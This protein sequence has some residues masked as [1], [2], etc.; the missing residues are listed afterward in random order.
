LAIHGGNDY[1]VPVLTEL[2]MRWTITDPAGLY[3][4]GTAGGGGHSGAILEK[5]QS[6][7]SMILIDRDAAAVDFCRKRFSGDPRV[8]TVHGEFKDIESILLSLNRTKI[9]GLL[10][11]LGLSSNQLDTVERG[12][13]HS[14]NGRLDM[15]MD[16]RLQQTAADVLNERTEEELAD[17]FHYYGEERH[18]RAIARRIVREREKRP[19]D[20]SE[21]LNQ[22]VRRTVSGKW[23]LKT[24]SRIYQALRIEVN[25]ELNQLKTGLEKAYPFLEPGG[26]VVVISYHSLEDRIVKQYFR[27][28]PVTF[29]GEGFEKAQ[30]RF[31]FQRLTRKVVRPSD[32][33]IRLN[34]RARS[35]K[36]RAAEKVN[37]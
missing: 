37:L 3:V 28:D 24:L 5:L 18:S 23:L 26:R 25:D 17:L 10:L 30:P 8:E 14:Q 35:A 31:L 32:D 27:G 6:G 12:F 13:S 33:E 36:L 20:T 11:D 2:V 16:S 4:D 21:S 15:R 9:N 19:F 22:A 1:H 7:G 29:F 34:S